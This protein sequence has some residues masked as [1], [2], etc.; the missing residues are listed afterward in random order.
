LI[1]L[2]AIGEVAHGIG[3][4]AQG[5]D[6]LGAHLGKD[7][8]I[9]IG[10]GV[11]EFHLNEFDGFFN[12]LADAAVGWARRRWRISAHDG[13]PRKRASLQLIGWSERLGSSIERESHV[14][15]WSMKST[16]NSLAGN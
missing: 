2:E 10:R 3:D 14:P 16:G 12:A 7:G 6:G 9:Q 5:G 13:M 15:E 1:A 8:V 4:I 11:A